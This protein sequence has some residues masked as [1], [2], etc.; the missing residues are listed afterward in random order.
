MV[1]GTASK[2]EVCGG[3]RLPMAPAWLGKGALVLCRDVEGVVTDNS[4]PKTSTCPCAAGTWVLCCTGLYCRN[5]ACL[6]SSQVDGIGISQNAQKH[7]QVT[8]QRARLQTCALEGRPRRFSCGWEVARAAGALAETACRT[9]HVAL[10][11]LCIAC[12]AR[13]H[14]G[15]WSVDIDV[16]V[17]LGRHAVYLIVRMLHCDLVL[18]HGREQAHTVGASWALQRA[19]RGE[20]WRG[21]EKLSLRFTNVGYFLEPGK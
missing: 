9:D 21:A 18:L 15:A 20:S 6:V 2:L 11:F 19:W 5:Q 3:N 17:A 1:S 14:G 4:L 16:G 10:C 8:A 13:P 7:V 12:F